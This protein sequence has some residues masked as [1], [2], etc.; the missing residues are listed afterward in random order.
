RGEAVYGIGRLAGR[1]G[2]VL[3]RQREK[4]PVGEGVAVQQEQPA[5]LACCRGLGRLGHHDGSLVAAADSGTE[6]GTGGPRHEPP[7]VAGQTAAVRRGQT[8][9]TRPAW[10][11]PSGQ[12]RVARPA[13][14]GWSATEVEPEPL[15]ERWSDLGDFVADS[16]RLMPVFYPSL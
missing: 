16:S 8:G 9:M 5:L 10:P 14:S 15:R 3:D 1:G 12:T 4:R 13:C 11:D 2:E 6:L 7:R